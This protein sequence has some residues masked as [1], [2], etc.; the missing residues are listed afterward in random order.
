MS[1]LLILLNDT[2]QA[3][4][5]LSEVFWSMDI[6]PMWPPQ[7]SSIIKVTEVACHLITSP[8]RKTQYLRAISD[9]K[10]FVLFLIHID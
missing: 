9:L 5:D 6:V 1:Y 7:L 4:S 8:P 3:P 10:T 2:D